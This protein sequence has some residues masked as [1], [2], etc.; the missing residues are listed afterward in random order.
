MLSLTEQQ[1]R[2][3]KAG[4][5]GTK[6]ERACV[7]QRGNRHPLP[8]SSIA[9]RQ[10]ESGDIRHWLLPWAGPTRGIWTSRLDKIGVEG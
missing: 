5:Y 3:H 6:K 1:H 10:T 4:A 8:A 2:L 7:L 9:K